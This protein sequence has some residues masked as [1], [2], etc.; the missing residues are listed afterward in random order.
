MPEKPLASQ[1]ALAS[2][3]V[4]PM[5]Y[6]APLGLNFAFFH[7]DILIY[8]YVYIYIIHNIYL[9]KC[10]FSSGINLSDRHYAPP[11]GTRNLSLRGR[12]ESRQPGDV[13]L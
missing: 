13:E 3:L 4:R 6:L 2:F 10:T 11:S 7:I 12:V 8:M 1:P 9:Y 5:E